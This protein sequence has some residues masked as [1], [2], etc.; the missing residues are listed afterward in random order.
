[1][2]PMI[3]ETQQSVDRVVNLGCGPGSLML[4]I[5]EAFPQARIIGE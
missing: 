5:L 2:V 4:P 1:M 3:C